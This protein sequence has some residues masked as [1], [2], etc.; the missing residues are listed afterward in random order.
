ME[1]PGEQWTVVFALIVTEPASGC[2]CLCVEGV[3]RGGPA[4]SR[5]RNN[6][7]KDD[8]ALFSRFLHG[9]DVHNDKYDN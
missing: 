7:Y 4:N 9:S 3:Q 1:E 5:F 2:V 6:L 8:S